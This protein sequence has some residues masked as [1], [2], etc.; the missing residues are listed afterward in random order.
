MGFGGI[1]R[2]GAAI[3][4]SAGLLASCA[5]DYTR[6]S[7]MS[8]AELRAVSSTDLCEAYAQSG[9]PNLGSINAAM[10][11]SGNA[12]QVM[13]EVRRRN[14]TCD[15]ELSYY[16]T[17]CSGLAIVSAQAVA[18]NAFAA[19]IQNRTTLPKRFLIVSGAIASETFVLEPGATR[20]YMIA[21]PAAVASVAGALNPNSSGISVSNCTT[22][23][24]Y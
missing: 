21:A 2:R 14:L 18:P 9:N 19:T 12:Q 7:R 15:R 16:R 11:G 5:S 3:V 6:L 23:R 1:A 17:D 10:F 24:P 20:A 8:E 13:A 4:V 22:A